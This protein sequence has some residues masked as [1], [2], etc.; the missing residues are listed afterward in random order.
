LK[1]GEVHGKDGGENIFEWFYLI[2]TIDFNQYPFVEFGVWTYYFSIT[3][4]I[5]L[6]F[7]NYI[8]SWKYISTFLSKPLTKRV[9]NSKISSTWNQFW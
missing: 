9:E 3:C 4:L 1:I 8:K 7:F 6:I 5:Y 2:M